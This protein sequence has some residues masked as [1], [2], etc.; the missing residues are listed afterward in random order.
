MRAL[1]STQDRGGATLSRG[2]HAV[3]PQAAG[4]GSSLF[5]A[6]NVAR[7]LPLSPWDGC[8]RLKAGRPAT[9]KEAQ[10]PFREGDN[11][12]ATV[13]ARYSSRGARSLPA[14]KRTLPRMCPLTHRLPSASRSRSLLRDRG[15]PGVR[16]RL[17]SVRSG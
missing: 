9:I 10:L 14:V 6:R 17:C 12:R 1:E 5:S 15:D 13:C 8:G 2:T 11:V 4:V 3:S 7:T 16:R